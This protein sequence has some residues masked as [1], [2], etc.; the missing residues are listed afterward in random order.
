MSIKTLN[1]EYWKKIPAGET[2]S[3]DV[4]ISD[5]EL[6]MIPHGGHVLDIGCGDGQLADYLDE[7]GF[8]VEAIDIN[9]NVIKA[10]QTK[11]SR[12]RYSQQDIAAGKTNFADG[13]FDLLCFKYTL[14][15]IHREEWPLVREEVARLIKPK[16][17]VWIAEPLIS[18][19]YQERYALAKELLDEY[20]KR[21]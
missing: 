11:Q 21:W 1:K 5:S 8:Q 13:M 14:A 3:V 17:F 6:N 4:T 2:T 19:D 10:N 7:K 9:Q 18:P 12:V 20:G 15:N 16:G